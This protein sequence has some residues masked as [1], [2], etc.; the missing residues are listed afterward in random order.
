MFWRKWKSFV[1]W[2]TWLVVMVKHLR[3]WV[4]ELVVWR[5]SSGSW[6]VKWCF[7]QEPGLSLKQRGK[8][9][10]CWV[11]PNVGTYYC[12]WDVVLWGGASYD[13]N[14]QWDD[15]LIGCWLM[16]LEIGWA[17][18]W[19]LRIWFKAAWGAMTMSFVETSTPKSWGYG[20]WNNWE[21]KE[22]L[23][24]EIVGRVRE[25]GFG[26]IWLQKKGCVQL[27]EKARTN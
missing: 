25:D 26:T 19:R 17:L 9:Y 14:D 7:S 23:T 8:I 24:K 2:V 18:L 22:G 3:H 11:R 10:Q 21:N 1:I 20:R 13:Q 5:R 15:W 6:G 16:F 4:Q 27:K 12:R